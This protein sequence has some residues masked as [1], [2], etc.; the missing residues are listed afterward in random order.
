MAHFARRVPG[1]ACLLCP[2]SSDVYLLGD[3]QRVIHL[4]SEIAN[5]AFD[6]RVAE[7]ELDRTDVPRA[8]VD[9]RRLGPAHGV[10]G[11][12]QRVEANTADPLG[13]EARV[14]LVV[15]CAS[16]PRRP[17]NKHWPGRRPLSLR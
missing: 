5:R 11:E 4:H 9:Q 10:R 15:R 13:D 16:G 6:L 12:L 17:A 1:R 8:T 3:L 7:Q 2:G 14:C